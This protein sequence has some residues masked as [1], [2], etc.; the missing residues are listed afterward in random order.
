MSRISISIPEQLMAKLEPI[1]DGINI[2]QLCRE[3]LERRVAAFERAAGHEALDLDG[4]VK[5]LQYERS[6]EESK[7]EDLGKD[8]AGRWLNA[9]SFLELKNVADNPSS[10][11][12]PKYKLP[13]AAFQIMK[14]DMAEAN[15]SCE[16]GQAIAYK[17]AWLDYVRSVWAQVV[18]RIESSDQGQTV[19]GQIEAQTVEAA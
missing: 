11:N 5:R 19:E 4:L 2:S 15:V 6:T 9:V 18:D 10:S 13:R 17:T 14:Q 12:L 1:K 16:G 3:A 7:F 8:N